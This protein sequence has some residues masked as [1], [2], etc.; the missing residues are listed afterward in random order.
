L[1]IFL[2]GADGQLGTDIE[3]Y[4]TEKGAEVTGLVGLKD[5]DICDYGSSRRLVM[6]WGPDL[7]INTAAFH[8]VDLCEDEVAQ[9][10]RVNVEGVKNIASICREA[11][12]P[13]MHFSTDYVFDGKKSFP[14]TEDD[15]PGPLSIYGI[16]KL[17][18]ERVIQ[19]MLDRYYLIR[20]CGLYGHA[21]CTGKGNTN[22]VEAMLGLASTNKSV[23]VV[24]DQVMTPTSS[25]DAA[26]KIFDLVRTGIYGLY[27]MTNTGS[28][29]WYE[30]AREIFRVAG[31]DV[32]VIPVKSS[33]F[34]AKALRPA[35]SV[36]D[37]V[38][39]RKAGIKD[40]RHWKEALRDYIDSR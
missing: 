24:D 33:E 3:K 8:N 20:L 14:Y 30:F 12:I 11:G 26:G 1:K 39:L 40:M 34:G 13:L 9:T 5:I 21:G 22:F 18:G 7:V 32:E 28:C 17:G 6:D 23:R 36:L 15:C 2:I 25:K 19:S 31:M 29:S 4:F 35:Y 27:H 10:F 37:N 16:S 38:N